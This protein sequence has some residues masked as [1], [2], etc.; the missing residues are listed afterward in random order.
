MREKDRERLDGC[1][2]DALMFALLSRQFFNRRELKSPWPAWGQ[3]TG[4]VGKLQLPALAPADVG[5]S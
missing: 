2:F 5:Q 3:V 1:V 4:G